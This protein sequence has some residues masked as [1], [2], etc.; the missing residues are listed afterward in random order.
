VEPENPLPAFRP[1]DPGIELDYVLCVKE[2]RT[3]IE[4][5]AFSYKGKRFNPLIMENIR[6]SQALL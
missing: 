5:G 2:K 1:L 6:V 3:V 4:D